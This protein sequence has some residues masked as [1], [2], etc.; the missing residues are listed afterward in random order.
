MNETTTNYIDGF[1][2]P[3]P[4]IQLNEYKSIAEKIAAIWK[5]YGA[6]AY[7][8]YIGDEMT[9]EGTRSFVKT[10]EAKEDEAIIFG[11]VVFPSKQTRDLANKQV[12]NDPRITELV[13]PITN[14]ERLIFDAS[15]MVYGGFKPLIEANNSKAK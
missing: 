14:P 12:P 11:W 7:F 8:E 9:L 15:R 2:F 5:E 13:A 3:V 1:I 6:L 10:L 4:K